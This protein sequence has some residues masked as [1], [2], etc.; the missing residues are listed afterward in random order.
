MNTGADVATSGPLMRLR[1]VIV[2][3]GDQWKKSTMIVKTQCLW[4]GGLG[5]IE[6]VD[7]PKQKLAICTRFLSMGGLRLRQ[8]YPLHAE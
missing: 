6:S 8:L 2:R 3:D 4:L 7:C 5:F 1:S